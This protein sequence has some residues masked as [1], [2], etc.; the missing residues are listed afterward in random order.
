MPNNQKWSED[1]LTEQYQNNVASYPSAKLP[2]YA[3]GAYAKG[4]KR[5][6]AIFDYSSYWKVGDPDPKVCFLGIVSRL[7]VNL[8]IV[9]TW[10]P[11]VV[12]CC[13]SVTLPQQM[14]LQMIDLFD[15]CI[16]AGK[17]MDSPT[18]VVI[19]LKTLVGACVG[20]AGVRVCIGIF[21]SGLEIG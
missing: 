14:R 1:T 18:I 15:A 16:E 7:L 6:A 2:P 17:V 12:P 5:Q 8:R 13:V 11:L 19:S 4:A 21:P 10:V 9:L 3:D 20:Y